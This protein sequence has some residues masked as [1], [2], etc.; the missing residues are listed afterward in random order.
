MACF[1]VR[2]RQFSFLH[3]VQ[4]SFL[5]HQASY[6][7]RGNFPG[8]KSPG[9]KTKHSPPSSVNVKNSGATHIHPLPSF[10]SIFVART[11][12]T[13]PSLHPLYISRKSVN[14]LGSTGQHSSQISHTHK[15]QKQSNFIS[16]I[17]TISHNKDSQN[18]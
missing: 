5:A 13:L 9:Y 15:T 1:M 8:G 2:E 3:S 11:E 10:R 17:E 16:H 6:S 18:Q 14:M 7:T 12:T 4:T